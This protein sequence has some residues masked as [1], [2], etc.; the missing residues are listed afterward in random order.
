MLTYTTGDATQ[1]TGGGSQY[2]VHVCNDEGRWGS[3]FVVALSKRW[4][5]PE[6]VYR[7]WHAEH[8]TDR[9]DT[10]RFEL[11]YTRYVRVTDDLVIANMIAQRGTGRDPDGRPCIRYGA[12]ERCLRNV[13]D[14][15]QA[16][17]SSV[18]MPRIGAGLAGGDWKII[19]GI[20]N[21]QMCRRG[22]PVTVYDLKE[23]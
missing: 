23:A 6:K 14:R 19:E 10:A 5:G 20:V 13:G 22:I 1:P 16:S 7:Q 18:H 4:P 21:D 9:G 15:A 8:L 3:G 17:G 2:I 12:L 11:G